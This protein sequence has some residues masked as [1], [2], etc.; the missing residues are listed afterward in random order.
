MSNTREKRSRRCRK[1]AQVRRAEGTSRHL[2][3]GSADSGAQEPMRCRASGR[4]ESGRRA[5]TTLHRVGRPRAAR[6]AAP[7]AGAGAHSRPLPAASPVEAEP[8]GRC[9][10]RAAPRRAARWRTD[11]PPRAAGCKAA[12][13]AG[14]RP[15]PAS[16]RLRPVRRLRPSARLG[17][18]VLSARGWRPVLCL[19][20]RHRAGC[21]GPRTLFCVAASFFQERQVL[22]VSPL[23]SQCSDL[24][25]LIC[26]QLLGPLDPREGDSAPCHPW[27]RASPHR[28]C[29][30]PA[31]ESRHHRT[32]GSRRLSPR[33]RL[34]PFG[35]SRRQWESRGPTSPELLRPLTPS[36]PWLRGAWV[37]PNEGARCLG[38]DPPGAH[39]AAP[40][41][42][43]ALRTRAPCPSRPALCTGPTRWDTAGPRE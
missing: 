31:A 30:Q 16:S 39:T 36:Q 20:C 6:G 21:L 13:G 7:G 24:E 35:P 22:G 37:A 41:S 5:R 29:F 25:V 18:G 27:A 9:G 26:F 1:T 4:H 3:G 11:P 43:Q 40:G 33:G 34:R 23:F 17:G 12:R 42:R 32:W 14:R 19:P 10:G 8:H 38:R 28:R 2:V 15:R